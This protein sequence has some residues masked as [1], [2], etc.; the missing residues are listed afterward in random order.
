LGFPF[1]HSFYAFQPPL[2]SNHHSPFKNLC[3]ILLFVGTSQGDLFGGPPF[4]T[5]FECSKYFILL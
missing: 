2:V 5:M 4:V 1:V 3:A